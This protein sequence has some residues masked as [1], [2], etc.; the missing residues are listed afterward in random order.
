MEQALG[1]DG[2]RWIRWG[3]AVLFIGVALGAFGAHALA[4][5]L[6]DRLL[7]VFETGVRYQFIHGLALLMLGLRPQGRGGAWAGS[8]FAAGI[9]FFSGSLYLLALTGVRPWGA[10]A[11]IGGALF[12][13][14]WATLLFSTF[15][16]R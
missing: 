3:S 8:F 16:A 4:D 1:L 9:V 5:R 6:D 7:A 11:P 13:A 2:R 12:L 14:G 10:V 15:R